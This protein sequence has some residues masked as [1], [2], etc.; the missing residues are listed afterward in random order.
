MVVDPATAISKLLEQFIRSPISA[1]I[2]LGED[3]HKAMVDVKLHDKNLHGI[4]L[5]NLKLLPD[6]FWVTQNIT[7]KHQSI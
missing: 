1:S 5:R 2:I 4:V 3:D 6:V 7:F